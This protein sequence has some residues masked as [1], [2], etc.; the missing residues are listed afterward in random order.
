MRFVPGRQAIVVCFW[1]TPKTFRQE[2]ASLLGI[3]RDDCVAGA[4]VGWV[5]LVEVRPYTKADAARLTHEPDCAIPL[6]RANARTTASVLLMRGC[7]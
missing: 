2:P 6:G 3:D 7:A 5:E 1:F 4:F